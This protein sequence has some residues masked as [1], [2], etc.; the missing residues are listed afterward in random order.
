MSP[1]LLTQIKRR[2]QESYADILAASVEQRQKWARQIIGLH[3]TV[4][5]KSAARS[6]SILIENARYVKVQDM[7]PE[8]LDGEGFVDSDKMSFKL[9]SGWTYSSEPYFVFTASGFG[10]QD[11]ACVPKYRKAE[12]WVLVAKYRYGGATG[13]C[14]CTDVCTSVYIFYIY[15]SVYTYIHIYIYIHT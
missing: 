12:P 13:V 2:F 1:L 6:F 14:V 15:M 4:H 3:A 5:V 10:P 9:K 8:D 11:Y 7:S